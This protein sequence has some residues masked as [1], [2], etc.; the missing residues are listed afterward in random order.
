MNKIKKK[1]II[2]KKKYTHGSYFLC[3]SLIHYIK[4]YTNAQYIRFIWYVVIWELTMEGYVVSFFRICWITTQSFAFFFFLPLFLKKKLSS[5]LLRKNTH[6]K[7]Y[8]KKS[9]TEKTIIF[10]NLVICKKK[11]LAKDSHHVFLTNKNT[12][13]K[14][15][16]APWPPKKLS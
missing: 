3:G 4:N 14:W 7:Q 1:I 6:L 13:K 5:T 12:T 15:K 9:M 16:T 2:K 8:K 11:I 10:F